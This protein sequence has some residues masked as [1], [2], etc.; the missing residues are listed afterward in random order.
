MDPQLSQHP[1]GMMAG[2]VGAD[3]Q[4]VGDGG[5]G[6]PLGQERGDLELSPGEAV[7]LLQV[8]GPALSSAVGVSRASLFLQLPP[9]LS[10]FPHRF[11]QLTEQQLAVSPQIRKCGQKIG[12]TIVRDTVCAVLTSLVPFVSLHDTSN[13]LG[14]CRDDLRG[15]ASLSHSNTGCE[16]IKRQAVDMEVA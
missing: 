11:A 5:I 13:Q 10:H 16:M 14:G 7:S 3:M 9:Q 6:P 1:L 12:Q 4:R 2:C 8:R 15:A